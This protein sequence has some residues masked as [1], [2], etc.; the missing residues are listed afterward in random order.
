M[1]FENDGLALVCKRESEFFNTLKCVEEL[2]GNLIVM[3]E[4]QQL[5]NAGSYSIIAEKCVLDEE[6]EDNMRI[7]LGYPVQAVF[8][9]ESPTYWTKCPSDSD[10][11]A[12]LEKNIIRKLMAQR[13]KMSEMKLMRGGSERLEDLS[14]GA[15]GCRND[16]VLS[17]PSK[18]DRRASAGAV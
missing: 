16:D 8:K 17:R 11:E 10:E 7:A 3:T 15:T 4:M 2:A 9:R 13:T 5:R 12:E 1:V 6:S 18:K 14:P